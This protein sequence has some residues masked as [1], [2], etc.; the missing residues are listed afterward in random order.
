MGFTQLLL[1]PG[2]GDAERQAF[3]GT[4]ER[5]GRLLMQ[6]IDDILD[7]S[8]IESG[9]M[10][11]ERIPC[12]LPGVVADV[13]RMLASQ[14]RDKG[15]SLHVAAEPAVP[16]RILTDPTRLK[17]I[18]INIIGNAIK[19][20]ETGGVEV[21]CRLLEGDAGRTPKL[22]FVVK[23][24]GRGIPPERQSELFRAFTQA[25]SSTTRKFGGTGLG[26][27]LS[28]RLAEA[29]GGTV[30]L[31]R[32]TPGEGSVF[33][34]TVLAEEASGRFELD[35]VKLDDGLTSVPLVPVETS[36]LRDVEVL[37]VEDAPDSQLLMAQILRRHGAK[38]S[39]AN[40]GEEAIHKVADHDYDV[41]LMDLQMPV[42]D[43]FETTA[44]LRR[45]GYRRPIV[46]VSAAAVKGDLDRAAAAGFDD[47]LVK[48]VPPQLLVKSVAQHAAKAPMPLH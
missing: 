42:K 7:L 35:A 10:S 28:R 14:A 15:I 11:I 48:P 32:S 36:L 31:S 16:A 25:D 34:I 12:S 43:G 17:Q 29:L 39:L 23:D 2:L 26:L 21:H 4:I 8:K 47:H 13:T 5:N 33:T 38:V 6:I 30:E 37:I 44:E 41:V 18:L 20:T 40:D 22:A 27:A 45:R 1:D 3:A 19:F 9:K 24:T 46:A